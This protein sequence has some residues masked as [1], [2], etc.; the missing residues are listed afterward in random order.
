M[1]EEAVVF[2]DTNEEEQLKEGQDDVYELEL[3]EVEHVSV[4]VHVAHVI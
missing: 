3:W 1:D 2:E 4:V